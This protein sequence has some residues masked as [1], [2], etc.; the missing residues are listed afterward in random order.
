[1][2]NTDARPPPEYIN[3]AGSFPPTTVRLSEWHKRKARKYGKGNVSEGLRKGVER[4]VMDDQAP[5]KD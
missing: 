2:D 4:L 5:R 3:Q 1:M